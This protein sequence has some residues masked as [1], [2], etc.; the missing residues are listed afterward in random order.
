MPLR[1]SG[2]C[3][4]ACTQR[5]GLWNR[6]HAAHQRPGAQGKH[7]V[8]HGARAGAR[9][10][11]RRAVTAQKY[12]HCTVCT[13]SAIAAQ[14][15][16]NS[17]SVGKFF[18]TWWVEPSSSRRSCQVLP[19]ASGALTGWLLPATYRFDH[20]FPI[21]RRVSVHADLAPPSFKRGPTRGP[22]LRIARSAHIDRGL[23]VPP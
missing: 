16:C 22:V 23:R 6:G 15:A 1:H 14:A 10:H 3:I 19:C 8:G 4:A 12:V 2:E 9:P 20:H 13:S 5:P 21:G 7:G 18:K 11:R 17:S